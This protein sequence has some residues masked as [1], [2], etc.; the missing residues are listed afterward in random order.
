MSA[1]R[2]SIDNANRLIRGASGAA[3]RAEIRYGKHELAVAR[4]RKAQALLIAAEVELLR[5]RRLV[6]AAKTKAR[7][8][9]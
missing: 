8:A 9:A 4:I 5:A 6:T 2:W 1:S 7:R 3:R